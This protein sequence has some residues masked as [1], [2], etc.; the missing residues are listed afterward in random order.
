MKNKINL[1]A[2]Q[3]KLLLYGGIIL[4]FLL[5]IIYLVFI[6]NRKMVCTS[7]SDQ[8][9]NGY[10]ITTTYEVIYKAG[11][12]KKTTITEK[13]TSKEKEVIDRFE[14]DWKDQYEYNKNT[15]GGYEYKLTTKKDSISSNIIIDYDK[16]N[17]KKFSRLNAAMKEYMK[18]DKLTIDGAQKMYEASGAKC[19]R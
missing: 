9:S 17:L 5:L 13:V 8:S 12:V 14:K 6:R 15:Y 4:L 3:K 10:K 18:D 16:F 19:K 2:Q 11:T 7:E 1:N